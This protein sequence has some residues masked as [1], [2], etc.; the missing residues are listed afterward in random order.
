MNWEVVVNQVNPTYG[1]C[2]KLVRD[3]DLEK[4]GKRVT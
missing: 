1:F 4:N 3:A 2:E